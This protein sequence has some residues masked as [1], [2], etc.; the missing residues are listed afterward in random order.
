MRIIS[1]NVS[2]AMA[3]TI[4]GTVVGLGV[5]G[6]G[7][8][9]AASEPPPAPATKPKVDAQ[10]LTY[11]IPDLDGKDVDLGQFKGKVV[12]L[13]NTAS[14][15]G[16]TAQYKDLEALYQANKDRGFVVLAFPSGDFANQEFAD[17]AAI[18]EFCSGEKSK[19]KVTFPVFGKMS[20]K[21]EGAH[22]L[23][24]QLAAQ[25]APIGGD[26]K[27]NFTKWLV[28]RQGNVVERF[29]FRVSPTSEEVTKRVAD[30]L[31]AKAATTPAGEGEKK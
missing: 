27:W 10:V 31:G 7:W 21:G 3:A 8:Q 6:A 23:F 12:L 19:Y 17:N 5:L 11:T 29:E 24:K 13:V 26:P 28:D 22:P 25:P 1:A 4:A 30:L 15:C 20:V 14:K 2:R 9:P 18:K 16:Y